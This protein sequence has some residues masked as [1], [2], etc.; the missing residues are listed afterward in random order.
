MYLTFSFAEDDIEVEEASSDDAW[1]EE[2]VDAGFVSS[3]G[4]EHAGE[5][6]ARFCCLLALAS[7]VLI[8]QSFFS[9][10]NDDGGDLG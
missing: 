1:A 6:G 5:V 3:E 2:S 9:W 4:D 10:D 8:S 7:S